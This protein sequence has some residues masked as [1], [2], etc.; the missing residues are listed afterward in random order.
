[1]N[2]TIVGAG[3][4]GRGI[5]TRLVAGGHAVAFVAKDPAKAEAVAAEL[6]AG[7]PGSEGRR[8]E[9]CRRAPERRRRAGAALR[10]GPRIRGAERGDA[11][12]QDGRR[13]LQP[14]ERHL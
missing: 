14:A 4:M 11:R 7:Q 10:R 5:A 13:H 8:R 6:R 2:I 9:P 12:R 3:N 1:M